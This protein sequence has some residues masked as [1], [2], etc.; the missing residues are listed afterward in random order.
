MRSS[1]AAAARHH[2]KYA[3]RANG[4]SSARFNHLMGIF[5]PA[6]YCS[7]RCRVEGSNS[8]KIGGKEIGRL[9]W[10][11][12]RSRISLAAASIGRPCFRFPPRFGTIRNDLQPAAPRLVENPTFPGPTEKNMVAGTPSSSLKRRRPKNGLAR[13]SERKIISEIA[14]PRPSMENR[15]GV[16]RPQQRYG[17]MILLQFSVKPDRAQISKLLDLSIFGYCPNGFCP[18]AENQ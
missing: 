14:D 13:N 18:R 2:L 17:P 4:I 7:R 11:E 5:P 12:D 10:S 3:L 9:S 8:V 1:Q 16:S 6:S 15:E